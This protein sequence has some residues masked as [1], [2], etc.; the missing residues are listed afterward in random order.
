MAAPKYGNGTLPPDTIRPVAPRSVVVNN[1][2]PSGQTHFRLFS[3]KPRLFEPKHLSKLHFVGIQRIGQI[4]VGN[5]GR[6]VVEGCSGQFRGSMGYRPGPGLDRPQP[7]MGEDLADHLLLFDDGNHTHF[8]LTRRADQG[9]DLVDL[10]DQPCPVLA[11]S[12]VAHGRFQN[13]GH[14]AIDAGFLVLAPGHVGDAEH[15]M[16][17]GHGLDDTGAKPFAEL[18]HALLM[19]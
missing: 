16:A 3:G 7:K 18:H 10:L 5:R 15:N 4:I 6:P 19:A 11:K 8:P 17:V 1:E 2:D 13:I 9:I 14:G 12:L